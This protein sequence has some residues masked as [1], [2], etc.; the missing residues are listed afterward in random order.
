MK[1]HEYCYNWD[2]NKI[3]NFENYDSLVKP[4][5]ACL[6]PALQ[7][8]GIRNAAVTSGIEDSVNS[9][10]IIE[11]Y[12]IFDSLFVVTELLCSYSKMNYFHHILHFDHAYMEV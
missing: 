9:R 3:L 2:K 12:E 5:C 7:A 6:S 1:N 4:D 11:A 8:Y 10:Q